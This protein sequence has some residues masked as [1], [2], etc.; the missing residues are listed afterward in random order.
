VYSLVGGLVPQS[1]GGCFNIDFSFY[2][3]INPFNSYSPCL[4]FPIG[5]L[6]LSPMFHCVHLNLY[7]SD[8]GRASQWTAYPAPV[9]K[10]FLASAIVCRWNG[11]LGVA[12]SGWPFLQSLLHSLSQHFLLTCGILD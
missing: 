8:S 5:D 4:N 12:V 7:W 3:V 2:E 10:H 6:A 1:S 11:S 9:S